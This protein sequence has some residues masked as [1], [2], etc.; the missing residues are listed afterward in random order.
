LDFKPDKFNK[1]LNASP[2]EVAEFFKGDGFTTGFTNT[3][4]REL[5]N[6]ENPSFGVLANRKR[7][8][9][10]KVDRYN[11][12]IDQKQRQLEK[13]E[14]NLRNKFAN[15]ESKMAGLKN[16]GAAVQGIGAAMKVP[17]GEG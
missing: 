1:I 17:G 2:A 4:K 9:R 6:L 5:G 12:Q 7:G 11:K 16:Q 15:L 3:L 10:E 13:K 8:I 14:E